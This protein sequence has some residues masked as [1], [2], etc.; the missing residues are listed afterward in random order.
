G[1]RDRCDWPLIALARSSVAF[2]VAATLV[3]LHGKRFAVFRPRILWM[4]SLAGSVSLVCTFYAF[5]RL[6]MA[7]VFTL[8]NMVPLW[9]ALL[10]WPLLGRAPSP[11]TW[12]CVALGIVGVVLIQPPDHLSEANLAVV[13]CVVSPLTSAVAL[14]GL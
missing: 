14:L 13:L 10:S 1:L 7:D 3:V 6:P 5:T 4:R 9:V 8:T 11:T 12:L 2:V